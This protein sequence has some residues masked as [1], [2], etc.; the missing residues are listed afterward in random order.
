MKKVNLLKL[1][2]FILIISVFLSGC[3]EID[4]PPFPN[5]NASW[6][7]YSPEDTIKLR[8]GSNSTISLQIKQFLI[9]DSY[10][11]SKQCDCICEAA[12]SIETIVDTSSLISLRA[13]IIYADGIN[14]EEPLPLK[15]S[16][17][18]FKKENELLI[19]VFDDEFFSN[20]Y[21]DWEM[22][23]SVKINEKYYNNVLTDTK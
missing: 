15:V 18:I 3:G 16:I 4:C 1:N 17:I 22:L 8:N 7:P 5:D 9:T 21:S 11:F 12:M 20:A 13:S 23:D 14:S 19:P 10:S 2:S 6:F